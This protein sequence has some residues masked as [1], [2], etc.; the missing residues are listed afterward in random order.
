MLFDSLL[1]REAVLA[2][3]KAKSKKQALH[4]LAKHAADLTT[5]DCRRIFDALIDRERLGS[6]GVGNGIAIPHARLTE[7]N[8]LWGLFARF[9][10]PVPFNAIDDEPVDLMFM[11][12]APQSCGAEHLKALSRVSRMLRDRAQCARLRGANGADALFS[13]L[14]KPDAQHNAA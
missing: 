13:I 14:V 6:T 12:L 9:V 2:D 8:R 1:S 7:I 5:V 10:S 11:L 4:E 3:L